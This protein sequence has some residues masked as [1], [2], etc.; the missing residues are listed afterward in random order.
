V[1]IE[2][3]TAKVTVLLGDMELLVQEVKYMGHIQIYQIILQSKW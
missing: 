2:F 1:E 3:V